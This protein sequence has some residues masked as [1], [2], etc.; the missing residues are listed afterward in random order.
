MP[1]ISVKEIQSKTVV[2]VPAN[3]KVNMSNEE[4]PPPITAYEHRRWSLNRD[5]VKKFVGGIFGAQDENI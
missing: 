1:K 3:T 5:A 2:Y 4:L